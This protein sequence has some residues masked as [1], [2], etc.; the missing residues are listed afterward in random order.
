MVLAQTE[1]LC[2]KNNL[3]DAWHFLGEGAVGNFI[4]EW[5]VSSL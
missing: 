5:G 3:G 1:G 2:I 4:M